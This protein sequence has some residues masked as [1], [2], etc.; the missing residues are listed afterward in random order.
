MRNA[1]IFSVIIRS[2]ELTSINGLKESR[3]KGYPAVVVLGH[4]EYY[5]RFGFVPSRK[6]NITSEYAVPPEAF[7]I[8]ELQPDVLAGQSGIARYHEAFAEL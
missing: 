6:Y 5:P 1:L 8:I 2:M 3:R 4:P 7:M